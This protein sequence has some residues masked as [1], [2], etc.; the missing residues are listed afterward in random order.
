MEIILVVFKAFWRFSL[1]LGKAGM[2]LVVG[3]VFMMRERGA[4]TW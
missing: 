4:G 2:V 1:P 3:E